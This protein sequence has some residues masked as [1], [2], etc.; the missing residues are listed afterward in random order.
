MSD[1]NETKTTETEVVEDEEVQESEIVEE[2]EDVAE[3]PA[4]VEG[5]E[6]AEQIED[7]ILSGK[8]SEF[9]KNEYY[10]E[11][12]QGGKI[13][14][15]L[16]ASAYA[17]LGLTEN[18]SIEKMEVIAGKEAWQADA[19]GM[20]LDTKQ[21]AFGT[22]YAPFMINGKYDPFSKQKAM[23]RAARNVRKQLIS[24]ERVVAAVTELAGIPNTLPPASKQQQL[25]PAQQ[26]ELTPE[27]IRET[28]NKEMFAVWNEQE[29]D[30]LNNYDINKFVFWAG[31]KVKC[32]IL[33]RAEMST[34]QMDMVV[35]AL[36]E[37]EYPQWV[38]ELQ[39]PNVKIK[40][41]AITEERKKDL[42]N[43]IWEQLQK[44]TGV[45]VANRLT[46]AQAKTCWEYVCGLLG[47]NP[48][49]TTEEETADT[50]NGNPN[51]SNDDLADENIPF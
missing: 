11:F 4:N 16:T 42:P 49:P 19:E 10:Y 48:D 32:G 18:I 29:T 21:K 33:S 34:D 5:W 14:R 8:S 47:I 7:L 2:H 25:P 3:L 17:H 35:K 22:G 46:I 30:L 38:K 36:R 20:R 24:Y 31:V 37:D 13:V 28:K 12:K 50:A 6:M 45:K 41:F 1:N 51:V 43:D 15:G 44:R 26:E 40:L 39:F 27:Q 9:A 23:T